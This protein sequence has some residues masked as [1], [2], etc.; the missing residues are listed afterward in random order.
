M[1]KFNNNNDADLY[2]VILHHFATAYYCYMSFIIL[3]NGWLSDTLLTLLLKQSHLIIDP[4]ISMTNWLF[5]LNLYNVAKAWELCRNMDTFP[6]CSVSY[7]FFSDSP[8]CSIAIAK[9]PA[10]THFLFCEIIITFRI[11]PH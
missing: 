7:L 3:R 6:I 10:M 11:P 4:L 8:L 2:L 9:I 1:C 5:I